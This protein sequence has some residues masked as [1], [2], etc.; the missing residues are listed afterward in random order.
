VADLSKRERAVLS[1]VVTE[2]TGTGVPV[3]SRTIAKKYGFDLSPA[4]I[5]NVMADLE[6]QGYLVQPHSSAGRVPTEAA[7]RLFIDALMRLRQLSVNDAARIATWFG[8]LPPGSDLLRGAGRLLSDMTGAAAIMLRRRVEDRTLVTLR[9]IR[10]RPNELLA[11][12]VC[13]DGTVE[14]RFVA[15]EDPP[16]DRELERL[17]NMLTEVVAGQT[18]ESVR[19]HFVHSATAHRDEIATLTS[20]GASLLSAALEARGP[21]D[22]LVIEGQA[23]LFERSESAPPEVFKDLVRAIEDKER[24]AELLDGVVTTRRVQVMLGAQTRDTLGHPISVVAAPYGSA[25]RPV[26]VL[27]VIGPTPL[28]YRSVIPVVRATAEAMSAAVDKGQGR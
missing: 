19:D 2:F 28:D 21:A 26:G 16:T 23:R 27:G 15:V 5:R 11:V 14:N 18:L 22:E 9:F 24:L 12:L 20:V 10:T 13:A 6:D 25:D 4:T 17:H 1:A 8:D 3:S 7:F